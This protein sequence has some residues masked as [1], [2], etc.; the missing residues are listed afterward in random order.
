MPPSPE[1]TRAGQSVHSPPCPQ[2]SAHPCS[3]S[4]RHASCAAN[5]SP[6]PAPP[7][8]PESPARPVPCPKSTTVF[9]APLFWLQRGHSSFFQVLGFKLFLPRCRC[10][11]IY[12]TRCFCQADPCSP[13]TSRPCT[14][15]AVSRSAPTF[16]GYEERCSGII[17]SKSD[18]VF[19]RV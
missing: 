18:S 19:F 3:L 7:P 12:R 15:P 5:P 11:R 2:S 16:A 4:A 1:P 14:T 8:S 10:Q 6:P 13:A 9:P 17:R